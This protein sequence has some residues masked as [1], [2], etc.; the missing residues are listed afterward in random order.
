MDNESGKTEKMYNI[1]TKRELR[2][3]KDVFRSSWLWRSLGVVVW[4]SRRRPLLGEVKVLLR[5]QLTWLRGGLVRGVRHP[6]RVAAL[7]ARAV[8]AAL[9]DAAVRGA[10]PTNTSSLLSFK[11]LFQDRLMERKWIQHKRAVQ[12]KQAEHRSH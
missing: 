3:C 2:R 7:T 4:R 12:Y 11:K 8:G 1:V 5:L 6:C 10:L 9:G